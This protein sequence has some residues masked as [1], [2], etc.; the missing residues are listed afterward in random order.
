MITIK[1]K[2]FVNLDKKQRTPYARLVPMIHLLKHCT[3]QG[4]ELVRLDIEGVYDNF[5]T[6]YSSIYNTLSRASS[7]FPELT[8]K[9]RMLSEDNEIYL[10]IL[11]SR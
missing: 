9:V 5:K 10:V 7:T 2:D 11:E 6:A 3:D 8:P 4:E 1:L